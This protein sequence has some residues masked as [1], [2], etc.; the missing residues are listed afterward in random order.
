LLGYVT[1]QREI[2]SIVASLEEPAVF[3]IEGSDQRFWRCLNT[4][5]GCNWM[6]PVDDSPWCRSCRM[7]RNRPDEARSD[8]IDAWMTAETAKRRLVHQLDEFALP[9]E[10]RSATNPDG[11]AFDFVHVPGLGGITGHRQGI[12]TLDLAEA[13]LQHREGLRRQLGEPFRTLI[14]HLRHEVGHHYW[15]RLVAQTDQLPAFRALFGDERR[16]Y[17]RALEDHY[18]TGDGSWDASAYVSA[19]AASHPAEDW[20]ETFA[21]YLHV[22]DAVDT[23]FAHRLTDPQL[24]TVDADS[25]HVASLLATWAPIRDAINAVADAVGAPIVYPFD[26]RGTVVDKL[27][28]V[29][30]QIAAHSRRDRFYAD[31]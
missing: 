4:A 2:R 22:V 21:H 7:T 3:V 26:L 25:M 19:Y 16:D 13:E 31:A 20:A 23:A 17:D 28:F 30:R 29:H 18:G 9:I 6:V 27:E 12:V 5:W 1:E 11:L 15:N 8:A 14:G 10:I 24:A